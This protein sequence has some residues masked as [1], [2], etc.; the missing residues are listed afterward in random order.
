MMHYIPVYYLK[1]AQFYSAHTSQASDQL[2]RLYL[3]EYSIDH[4]LTPLLS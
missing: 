3:K 1:I 2:R 4:G